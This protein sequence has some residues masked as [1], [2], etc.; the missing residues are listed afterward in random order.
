ME[1][2]CRSLHECPGDIAGIVGKVPGSFRTIATVSNASR[3]LELTYVA[4]GC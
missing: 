2:E 3:Y 1:K 4:V